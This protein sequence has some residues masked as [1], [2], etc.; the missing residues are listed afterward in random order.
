MI[1][2]RTAGALAGLILVSAG[3][4]TAQDREDEMREERL[5]GAPVRYILSIGNHP[6]VDG[7]RLN[8]RDWDL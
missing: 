4:L 3:A 1:S 6:R 2:I 8:Y 7:L 5:R